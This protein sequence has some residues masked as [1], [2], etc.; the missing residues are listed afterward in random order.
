MEAVVQLLPLVW[1]ACLTKVGNRALSAVC[2][3]ARLC[4]KS[5]NHM[6]CRPCDRNPPIPLPLS[7]KSYRGRLVVLCS[8]CEHSSFHKN[9]RECR[10]SGKFCFHHRIVLFVIHCLNLCGRCKWAWVHFRR[11]PGRTSCFP[12]QTMVAWML[13]AGQ[14]RCWEVHCP[15]CPSHKVSLLSNE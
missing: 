2:A 8:C 9:D 3:W 13:Q 4:S 10:P 5:D 12:T 7:R 11:T 15:G 6:L 1:S 14:F